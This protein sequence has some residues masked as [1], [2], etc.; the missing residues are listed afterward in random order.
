[1]RN[2]VIGYKDRTVYVWLTV[3][4]GIVTKAVTE[5]GNELPITLEFVLAASN[6]MEAVCQSTS[7]G[8]EETT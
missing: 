7:C 3:I 2:Q 6:Y 4:D 5:S 8:C 1:M